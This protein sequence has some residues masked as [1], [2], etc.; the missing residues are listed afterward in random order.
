MASWAN[1]MKAACLTGGLTL[2]NGGQFRLLNNVSAELANMTFST[3]A[4]P[5]ATAASPATATSNAIIADS[6]ITPGDVASF[7]LR[8]SAAATLISGSVGVGSGDLQVGSVTIPITAT[9]VSCPG[10]LTIALQIS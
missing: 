3:P 9:S 10:G 2:L 5:S 7:E 6:S 1:I 4:F 8:S